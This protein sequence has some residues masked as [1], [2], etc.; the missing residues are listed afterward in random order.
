MPRD[1][2]DE[3]EPSPGASS[4]AAFAA[5]LPPPPPVLVV[6]APPDVTAPLKPRRPA[7][8]SQPAPLPA[9]PAIT[10]DGLATEH[11]APIASQATLAAPA[12]AAPPAL[13]LVAA[14]LY[15]ADHEIAR[16]GMGRIVAAEDQRL[17]R[18]VALKVLLEPSPEQV[19][20]FQREALITARL[21]HPGIVPVYEAGRWPSGEPFFAM[22]LVRG[23]PL[24]RVIAD[25]RALEDRLALLP[26]IAAA[27]EAI[28]YAHSQ[29]VIHR[30]LK[31]ANVLIGDF[32]ETVVIDWG[33]AKSL[34]DEP[35]AADSAAMSA[36]MSAVDL[37][38]SAPRKRPRS[39]ST[40]K[41]LDHS[42]AT[43][44]VAGAVM[45]TPA[46]MAPEQARAAAVDQ[47]ADVFALGAMLYHLLAGA[48]PYNARTATEVIAAAA[49]G[50][51]TPLAE[52][53]PDAPPDLVAIVT[54]AMAAAPGDRYADAGELATELRRFLT[55]QLVSAHR[56]TAAQRVD[57]FVRKH[58]G[59]VTIAV[60][61]AIGFAAG[62]TFAVRRI[63]RERDAADHARQ[64]ADT[65]RRAAEHLIDKMQTDV[66]T[67]LAQIGRL[68]LLESLGGEIRDYY[69]AIAGLP[70]DITDD[71]VDR[72]AL[73]AELIGTAERDSGKLDRALATWSDARAQ[74]TRSLGDRAPDRSQVAR[75]TIAR[76]DFAI[77]TVYQQRGKLAQ[78]E[79]AYRTAERELDALRE[80]MPG[81]RGVLLGA[82]DTHD[83]LG[84]LLRNAGKVEQAFDEYVEAKAERER[85]AASPGNRPQEELLALSTSHLKLG[86]VFQAR[87]DATKAL[88]E[89]RAALKLRES[90]LATQRDD[91]EVQSKVLEIQFTLGD[92]QREV[93][94]PTSAIETYR[95]AL[96]VMD[97]LTR[98]DPANTAWRRLRGNLE[99]DYGFA[100]L[101]AGQYQAAL[102]QLGVAVTTQRALV[103]QD[104]EST[105]WQGDLSRSYT[106]AGDAALYLGDY[107]A[108]IARYQLALATRHNLVAKDPRSAPFRRS[109][110]WSHAKLAKAYTFKADAAH[111]IE[112]H[113]AA[114]AI[115]RVLVDESPG[116]G[117][118]RN[119]LASTEAALGKLLAAS[120]GKRSKALIDDALARS[121][122]LVTADPINHEYKET[123]VQG[124]LAQADAARVA[125]DAATR[126][127]ALAEALSVAHDV[128][129][130][131]AHN[132]HWPGL[133][134]EVQVGLAELATARGDR[135]AAALAWRAARD[136]LEPLAATGRLS[137]QRKP[138]LDR[139]R[140]AR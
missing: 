103:E 96:P 36:A 23:Q 116:Q 5:T 49:L 134:A 26:R 138:L 50:K 110:A 91:S 131:P 21:Q 118:F 124:L 83:R 140:A 45:G 90:L 109:V 139:A 4:S 69:A 122:A 119:E 123:L 135:A 114:L 130:R 92:L 137:A 29:R 61:A 42:T 70:G 71:E 47:R 13:P 43:L 27:T 51:V 10:G 7:T 55:G 14:E 93:G 62:G 112:A 54:R 77:G 11:M 79:Q 99:S 22:K 64:L 76:L 25:A 6:D 125:N 78:A 53:E 19:G 24:D 108:G 88:D 46:Y 100:L 37:A 59:A 20:R 128:V 115:R 121:R 117:G 9:H 30:D 102:D 127:R 63:V 38:P 113:E 85:A 133:L 57:R 136:A 98:R 101:D 31:P 129:D 39:P 105:T 132:V 75:R 120:D 104:P 8:P 107:D 3:A 111:A 72:M 44:T 2:G 48:P 86:S 87:G 12:A 18:A 97:A 28:A 66:R 17:G 126:G 65:R 94:D 56:Y 41:R 84:D 80:E 35:D 40:V 74:L 95:K 89:Y 33:L 73:A 1:A 58:R 16:G 34:D 81:E 52:R 68:D 67:R 82:A 60:L 15:R 32:G 106:R